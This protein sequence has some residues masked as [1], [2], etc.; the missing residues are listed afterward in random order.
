MSDKA[1]ISW[2]SFDAGIW[3]LA[4]DIESTSDPDMIVGVARGGLPGAVMLSHALGTPMVIAEAT[5]YKDGEKQEEIEYGEVPNVEGDLLVFDDVVDT[6]K[7]ME[8]ITNELAKR[9]AGMIE[10]ASFHIKEDRE[11]TPDFWISVTDKWVVY[12]WEVNL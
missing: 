6:G 1:H 12:P 4:K 10:T 8:I 3:S 5:H 9:T 7:T 11:M 2:D